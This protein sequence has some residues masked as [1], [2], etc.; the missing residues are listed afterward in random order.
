ME[1]EFLR[2]LNLNNQRLDNIISA[3]KGMMKIDPKTKRVGV[4]PI[5]KTGATRVEH[6]K[7]SKR[8]IERV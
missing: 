3:F 4:S 6:D 7:S 1:E 8:L 2:D 5:A